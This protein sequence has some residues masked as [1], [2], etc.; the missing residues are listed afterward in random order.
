MLEHP[1][2]QR[3]MSVLKNDGAYVQET[4]DAELACG[5]IGKGAV[6][7]PREAIDAIEKLTIS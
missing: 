5:D 1:A 3:N 6:L 4:R 7:K 2:T